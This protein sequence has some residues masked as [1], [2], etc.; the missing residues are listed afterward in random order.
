[1][2]YLDAIQKSISNIKDRDRIPEEYDIMIKAHW[3]QEVQ[4]VQLGIVPTIIPLPEFSDCISTQILYSD[5]MKAMDITSLEHVELFILLFLERVFRDLACSDSNLSRRI[6]EVL[7]F[8]SDSVKI[9][10]T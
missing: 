4:I 8:P 7:T 2:N 5:R 6:A 10:E 1:V 9:K 3:E